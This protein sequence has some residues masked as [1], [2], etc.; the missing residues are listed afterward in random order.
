MFFKKIKKKKKNSS[1]RDHCCL[2]ACMSTGFFLKS[3]WETCNKNFQ[4]IMILVQ[5]GQK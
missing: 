1:G 2:P 3:V 5:T 4:A